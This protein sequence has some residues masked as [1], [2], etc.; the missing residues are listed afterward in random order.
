MEDAN[1]KEATRWR[2]DNFHANDRALRFYD[3]LDPMR[4]TPFHKGV[5]TLEACKR[6]FYS[7]I[8]DIDRSNIII[9]DIRRSQGRGT[10]TSMELMY[11]WTKAK[12]IFLLADIDDPVHPFCE[13]IYYK[14]CFFESELVEEV[15]N[16]Y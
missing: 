14:K 10:G 8:S 6:I 5:R 13:S 9:A 16:F 4:R 11:A 2:R 7:D 15:I 1:L 12:P 3:F